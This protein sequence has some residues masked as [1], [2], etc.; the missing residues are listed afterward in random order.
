MEQD[1]IKKITDEENR[2]QKK[3]AD[4]RKKVTEEKSRRDAQLRQYKEH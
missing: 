4:L 3:Q 1:L 2:Y